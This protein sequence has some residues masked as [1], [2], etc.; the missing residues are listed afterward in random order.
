MPD[1]R[2]L[3]NQD[4]TN[5]SLEPARAIVDQE[6]A[7]RLAQQAHSA[8]TTYFDSSIRP[9][10]LNDL[11]QFQ[12][13]HPQGSKFLSDAYRG[14]NRFFRPKTRA[15]VRKNEAIAAEA[16][17]ST[18]DVLSVK[19]FDDG[20]KAQQASA[21]IN[22]ALLQYRLTH[23]I[24][25]FSIACGAYQDAQ[26]QGM[27]CSYQYW[28]YDTRKGLDRPFVKLRPLENI[29]FDPS[30][31]WFDPVGTSP[32]FIDMIPMYVKDVKA[33]M[34][35]IDP[36]TGTPKWKPAADAN[37]LKASSMYSNIVRLQREQG[38]VDPS[39]VNTGI[40]DFTVVWVH[41]NIMDLDG[42]D[43]VWHTL[44]T[45]DILD[46]PRPLKQAYFHGRRPYVVGFCVIETHKS[47]PAGPVRLTNQ[48]QGEL[49]TNANQ[50]LDNVAFAMNKR[51]FAKRTA[52]VDLASLRRN[53]PSSVT[54]M[55]DP[56]T[57]VKVV[58]TSDVTASAYAEQDRL[59]LDFDDLMGS[60][61][62]ASVQSNRRLNETVGGMQMLTK[63]ASQITGYQLRTFAETWME[64]VLRQLV[65]LEQKYEENETILALA[66]KNAQL[67]QKFGINTVT[68]ELLMAE[69]TVDVN[70]GIGATNP[71]DQLT[72]FLEAMKALKEILGDGIL[73][74]YGVDITEVIHEIFGKLGYKDGR[75]FFPEPDGDP[76]IIGLLTQIRTLQQQLQAKR[77]QEEVD[78]NVSKLKEQAALIR[79]QKI[80]NL[81][82]SIFSAI[83]G[84][85]V[86]AAV[87]QVAP[88]ADAVLR[89]AGFVGPGGE[90]DLPGAPTAAPGLAVQPVM[91]RRTG[92]GFTPGAPGAPAAGLVADNTHPNLPAPPAK[93]ASPD[94]GAQRGIETT[95]P[96][97]APKGA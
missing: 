63:D 7:L 85:E 84:A 8:S 39:T 6:T 42:E 74:N 82:E 37:L 93:P 59:N 77:P 61:S 27:V 10:L 36:A 15:A 28:E 22:Q 23:S 80:K 48:I 70:V 2:P 18:A 50:R 58:E 4:Q 13:Q 35:T 21:E 33:R 43:Y 97:S 71:H 65:L 88:P 96:D 66:A 57:D 53:V 29:R 68:D 46:Q 25:W 60:F 19:P 12:G 87:P 26:V 41:R 44:G 75:R 90:P 5:A 3:D 69:L 83:Q 92:V 95:R 89:Q 31:D 51:Y 38:R 64:P 55:N 1:D 72:N 20:D 40:N 11:R 62:Q 16:F 67:Y 81:V 32:Y 76:R 52:Q 17:F 73:T 45:V 34:K 94:A 78:A 47:Y 14:R 54:L 91:N 24:P 56:E 30:A 49:N 79:S 9:A 86:L